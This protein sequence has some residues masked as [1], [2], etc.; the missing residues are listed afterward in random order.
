MPKIIKTQV[1]IFPKEIDELNELTHDII[2]NNRM[3][4]LVK[5]EQDID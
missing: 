2:K 5:K 1:E 3:L 4:K